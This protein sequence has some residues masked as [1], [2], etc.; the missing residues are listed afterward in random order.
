MKKVISILIILIFI[1]SLFFMNEMK[2]N[3]IN[4]F[5]FSYIKKIDNIPKDY[6][7]LI[8]MQYIYDI[9]IEQCR[10][11]FEND[12]ITSIN[13]VNCKDMVEV[14]YANIKQNQ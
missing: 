10:K 6:K 9:N 12:N 1:N 3:N 11:I 8:T 13:Y 5:H 4:S 2:A 14:V 7:F